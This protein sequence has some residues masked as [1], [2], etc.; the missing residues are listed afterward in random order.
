[1]KIIEF[2]EEVATLRE[3]NGYF[4]NVG[5]A[6]AI[7]ILGLMSGLKNL[8]QIHRWAEHDKVRAFLKEELGI[9][10]I[11]CYYWLTVMMKI[12]DPESLS[13]CF[14]EWIRSIVPA[15][16]MTISVDGKEIRSMRKLKKPINIVSAQIAEYG[17]T[18]AQNAVPNKKNEIPAV[19]ELL[20]KLKIKNCLIVAD[21]LHCQTKTAEIIVEKKADYLLKVKSNQKDLMTEI[22][23]YVDDESLR[24][25]MD[26]SETLEKNRGRIEKRT[27]Y[28]ISKISW[29]YG[30][31]KWSNLK[32]IGA[33]CSEVT[34]KHKTTVTWHYYISSRVLTAADLLKHARLEWSVETMHWLLDVHFSEDQ[35]RITDKNVQLTLNIFRKVA[36]NY[37]K[38]YKEKFKPKS[39]LNHI[40]FDCLMNPFLLKSLLF[41]N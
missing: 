41:E 24:S 39:P 16:N 26:T 25:E 14:S 18:I 2:F 37:V 33:I 5:Q 34:E 15:E 1:M 20:S 11:P 9:S 27:A 10:K 38:M 6:I 36:I 40:M 28:T 3:Y 35:C 13:E 7:V 19:Q 12:I 23:D 30:R 4:Y 22:K 32:C 31:E 29:L 8:N 21:A 17:L